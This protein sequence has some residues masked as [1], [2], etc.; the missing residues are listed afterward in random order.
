MAII[1]LV[2]SRKLAELASDIDEAETVVEEL[3]AEP[4]HDVPDKLDELKGALEDASEALDELQNE[5]E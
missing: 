2:S 3:E 5:D 4:D 1:P